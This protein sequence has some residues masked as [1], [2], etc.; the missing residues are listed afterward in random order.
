MKRFKRFSLAYALQ[1]FGVIMLFGY[2]GCSSNIKEQ[3]NE[4]GKKDKVEKKHAAL[5]GV[6]N[7]APQ[8]PA[9]VFL[10]QQPQDLQINFSSYLNFSK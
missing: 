5:H 3:K 2:P 10:L 8:V 1:V 6:L 4:A 9:A 7:K